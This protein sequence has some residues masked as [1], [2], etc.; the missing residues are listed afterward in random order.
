[1][2]RVAFAIAVISAAPLLYGQ[3]RPHPTPTA[4][5]S[6][7]PT[8]VA[9]TPIDET[10]ALDTPLPAET[11]QRQSHWNDENA[12]PAGSVLQPSGEAQVPKAMK[13]ELSPSALE[14]RQYIGKL[15]DTA[16]SP[17]G[18][19]KAC[20]MVA[21]EDRQRLT[22]DLSQGDLRPFDEVVQQFRTQWK[23]RYAEDFDL[24]K[25]PVVLAEYPV[26]RG[27]FAPGEAIVASYRQDDAASAQNRLPDGAGQEQPPAPDERTATLVI[28]PNSQ[29]KQ[30]ALT[31]RFNNETT[32]GS[33]WRL[34]ASDKLTGK[35]LQ[36]NLQHRL[37]KMMETQEGWPADAREAYR[38]MGYQ[39]L[40]AF[41]DQPLDRP[42]QNGGGKGSGPSLG[43]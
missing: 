31:V 1:M 22:K 5:P 20:G 18:L 9:A 19:Q 21:L 10:R 34:K 38:L 12:Q 32:A 28:P 40:A 2:K 43:S 15:A 25:R 6:P 35:K 23:A 37:K 7:G 41:A 4:T 26:L 16:L 30:P 27:D 24:S 39:I 11:S 29:W 8:S 33:N 42:E 3:N 36:E 17:N 14:I 13:A